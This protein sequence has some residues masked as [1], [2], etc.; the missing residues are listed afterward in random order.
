[1]KK[2]KGESL[3]S[4]SFTL[5]KKTAHSREDD[6]D[7]ESTMPL[8]KLILRKVEG[9]ERDRDRQKEI[10][11]VAKIK[12]NR[13]KDEENELNPNLSTSK[14]CPKRDLKRQE[15]SG[16]EN[17]SF[18]RLEHLATQERLSQLE[19]QMSYLRN[20]LSSQQT[21]SCSNMQLDQEPLARKIEN[22]KLFVFEKIALFDDFKDC[23]ETVYGLE[24]KRELDLRLIDMVQSDYELINQ[25]LDILETQLMEERSSPS[26]VASENN[27]GQKPTKIKTESSE[28][29]M[30]KNR[31]SELLV[32]E[33][34][35][36]KAQIGELEAKF[37]QREI[38]VKENRFGDNIESRFNKIAK[39]QQEFFE[40]TSSIISNLVKK[41]ETDITDLDKKIAELST[42]RDLR[43]EIKPP[44]QADQ[45]D[46]D[47]R[48]PTYRFHQKA[49]STP[50]LLQNDFNKFL[51]TSMSGGFGF[52]ELN[53][54]S[55][56]KYEALTE[57]VNQI[58][59]S[60]DEQIN[61]INNRLSALEIE[62]D[63]K[64]IAPGSN[65]LSLEKKL[66]Q[67]CS[68]LQKKVD[69]KGLGAMH[70]AIDEKCEK[71]ELKKSSKKIFKV[72]KLFTEENLIAIYKWEAY[73]TLK[74][75]IIQ[76]SSE[77]R[78][79]H[80]T[81]IVWSESRPYLEIRNTGLYEVQIFVMN[82]SR[83]IRDCRVIFNDFSNLDF[84][85]R[86]LRKARMNGNGE[87]M[88]ESPSP[89]HSGERGDP[90]LMSDQSNFVKKYGEFFKRE[91]IWVAGGTKL[92]VSV[93]GVD[94]EVGKGRRGLRKLQ[95]TGLFKLQKIV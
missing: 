25:R 2:L 58:R 23:A 46:S 21:S 92:G 13:G 16:G 3:L 66:S 20:T 62:I 51:E 71:S 43:I 73:D 44:N 86:S 14:K 64:I 30:F 52:A 69:F 40:E 5:T 79:F 63:K 68:E 78:N 19:E 76:F 53:L 10:N 47:Q 42:K 61:L 67:V 75:G 87:S 15:C 59:Q 90:T 41:F 11:R 27:G 26:G 81:G 50:F 36:L 55:K 38:N 12:R 34:L 83:K 54:H 65:H 48:T 88:F 31:H 32:K 28:D 56:K 33:I 4:N 24:R 29:D 89:F 37:Y 82:S 7:A 1:M 93:I 6:D 77:I 84:F 70:Q 94:S 57:S 74:N 45:P 80:K 35:S 9:L 49:Q 60:Q 8:L 85:E 22:L 91:T 17:P 39:K 95:C 18:W 72:L